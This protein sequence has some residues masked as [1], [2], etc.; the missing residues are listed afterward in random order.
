MTAHNCNGCPQCSGSGGVVLALL[1]VLAIACGLALYMPP[2]ID[3][4]NNMPRP[5]ELRQRNDSPYR[6]P[7]YP[8]APKPRK[9]LET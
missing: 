5:T 3:V 1:A 4:K 2:K 7:I 6:Y 8:H 9:D